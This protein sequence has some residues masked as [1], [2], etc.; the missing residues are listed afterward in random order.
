LAVIPECL[1]VF[2]AAEADTKVKENLKQIDDQL[3]KLQRSIA[4][5]KA[6]FEKFKRACIA[7]GGN[8][9]ATGLKMDFRVASNNWFLAVG[10]LCTKFNFGPPSCAPHPVVGSSNEDIANTSAS[11]TTTFKQPSCTN[12]INQKTA[13]ALKAALA[14]LRLADDP[15]DPA[16][17]KSWQ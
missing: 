13:D 1:V 2:C 12:Q 11:M 4:Q 14:V 17:I 6:A 10:D 9:D 8:M 16:S 3:G 5:G 15:C 7:I